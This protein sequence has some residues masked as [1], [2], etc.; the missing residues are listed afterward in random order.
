[1]KPFFLAAS[2]LVALLLFVS[3]GGGS[4]VAGTYELDV[5]KLIEQTRKEMEKE[6]A[7][8]TGGKKGAMD[9]MM[10]QM[11][12]RMLEQLQK[13]KGRI[14]LHEDGTFEGRMDMGGRESTIKG[15]WKLEGDRLTM[16]SSHQNGK[17]KVETQSGLVRGDEIH[18]ETG[19]GGRKMTL[20]LRRKAG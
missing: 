8:R 19:Q 16:T 9:A 14:V 6:T 4:H 15:T 10:Q 3:C 5:S 7:A 13:T 18:I 2:S 12:A 17:E 1:M 20:V 11:M